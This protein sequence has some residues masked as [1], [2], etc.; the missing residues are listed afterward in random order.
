MNLYSQFIESPVTTIRPTGWLRDFLLLQRDGLTGHLE[1]GGKPFDDASISWTELRDLGRDFNYWGYYEQNAY[2]IDGMLRCGA[3]LG[4]GFLLNKAGAV[5]KHVLDNADEDGYL[6]PRFIKR[7]TTDPDLYTRWSHAIFFR[8]LAA[9]YDVT[10]DE[11]ILTKLTRHFINSPYDYT[12]GRNVCNIEAM[13]WLYIKTGDERLLKL[14]EYAYIEMDRRGIFPDESLELTFDYMLSE[15]FAD[16]HG[17]SYCEVG[18]LGA[19]LYA[20]TGK[21]KY[22]EISAS[23]YRKLERYSILPDG[24][25]S[26]AEFMQGHS[27]LDS[28]ET[29]VVTDYTWGLGYLLNACGDAAYADKMEKAV[30]NALP[31]CVGEDFKTLQY[32]SSPNQ[33]IADAHSNHNLF[34]QGMGYM[35]F[36][37]N[38]HTECCAG[39]VNR[40]MPDFAGRMWLRTRN[41]GIAAALYGPSEFNAEVNGVLVK[42]TEETDY[43]FGEAVAFRFEIPQGITAEFDFVYRIP[44]WAEDAS[45]KLNGVDLTGDN[46]AGSFHTLHRAFVNGDELIITLPM[47]LRLSH[48]PDNGVAVERGPLTYALKIEQDWRVNNEDNQFPDG[49]P[50]YDVYAASPWNYALVLPEGDEMKFFSVN[51]GKPAGER[52]YSLN[53]APVTITA[54]ARRINGWRLREETSVI[55]NHIPFNRVTEE[56]LKTQPVVHGGFKFTPPLSTEDVINE[57]AGEVEDVT[58]IPYGS[59]KLRVSVFPVVRG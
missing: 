36:R 25:P 35:S 18:K 23:A 26:T 33:V 15:D 9:Y 12:T 31:G 49:F 20:V 34:C 21:Q 13:V 6:G 37:P 45:V 27:A 57:T 44:V 40:A 50:A 32:F 29:C 2:W 28:H 39:N 10:G 53:G 17:V 55:E 30:Y 5:I 51:A 16:C 8:A 24:V 58:L 42:V 14:A 19:V 38:H 4:D 56:E 47:K 22:Y 41:G 43:P 11:S 1:N 48:W 3:L 46:T 52:P 54:K 7:A 59:A